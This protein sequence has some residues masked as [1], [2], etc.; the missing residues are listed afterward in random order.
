MCIGL[1]KK[2]V[3][4]VIIREFRNA[5]KKYTAFI[6]REGFF[7]L[8]VIGRQKKTLQYNF[9]KSCNLENSIEYISIYVKS[10]LA[11]QNTSPTRL[12][13]F[14]LFNCIKFLKTLLF[15]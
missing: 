12:T 4:L 6:C 5:P 7:L 1:N 9:N 11:A 15:T 14:F 13:L 8:V 2:L 10:L 3:V